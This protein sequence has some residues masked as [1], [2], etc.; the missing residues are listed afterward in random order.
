QAANQLQRLDGLKKIVA[1]YEGLEI[2]DVRSSNISH[3]EAIQQAA[4]MLRNHPEITIM[5]GTS[6]TD[7]L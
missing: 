7:A 5:V 4:N 3:M 2:V 1:A 6:A